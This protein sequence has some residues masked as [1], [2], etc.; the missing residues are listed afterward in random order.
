MKS[1]I[2]AFIL[3]MVL[4]LAAMAGEGGPIPNC[5]PGRCGSS[6]FPT[7]THAAHAVKAIRK[8]V[9]R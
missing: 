1:L 3:V 5:Q 6:C 9:H 2:G 8:A 7:V 4:A